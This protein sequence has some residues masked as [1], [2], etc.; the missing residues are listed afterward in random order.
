MA[1]KV[2]VSLVDDLTGDE[3]SETISFAVDGVTYE[4]DLNARNAAKLRKD[5][6]KYAESARRVK[7]QVRQRTTN[8]TNQSAQVRAWA[9]KNGIEVGPTGRIPAAV[10]RQYEA[11]NA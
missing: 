1:Q 2:T 8:G 5:L 10:V 6:G 3:A 9:K 7:G 11:A 4:I